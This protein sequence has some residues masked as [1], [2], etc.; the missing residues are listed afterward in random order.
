MSG[1]DQYLTSREAAEQLG[2][3]LRTV[4]LWVESGVLRAWKT[5]GGHRRIERQSV[6]D[7]LRARHK[8]PRD[9]IVIIGGRARPPEE[10]GNV[11]A[12]WVSAEPPRFFSDHY[13]A[14]LHIGAHSPG[15]VALDLPLASGDAAR[16]LEALRQHDARGGLSIIVFGATPGQ[17]AAWRDLPD[18]L[19]AEASHG[20]RRVEAT[21]PVI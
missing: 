19:L 15:V 7:F 18:V 4:Q 21:A 14:L 2:V 3:S 8:G 1:K 10:F 17:A 13:A 5:V 20:P 16:L 9:G 6:E 12:P 11:L